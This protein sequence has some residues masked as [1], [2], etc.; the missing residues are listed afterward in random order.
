MGKNFTEIDSVLADLGKEIQESVKADFNGAKFVAEPLEDEPEKRENS[1]TIGHCV[2]YTKGGER[3]GKPAPASKAPRRI[4]VGIG[5][6]QYKDKSIRNLKCCVA[7]A[8]TMGKVACDYLGVEESNCLILVDGEATLA[9][10]RKIFTDLLPEYTQVGDEIFVYWSGHGD[11]AAS[12]VTRFNDA[13]LVPSDANVNDR[14]TM[15]GEHTFGNWLQN[16]LKGRKIIL[17]LDACHSSGM[18]LGGGKNLR[19]SDDEGSKGGLVDIWKNGAKGLTRQSDSEF[20][21]DFGDSLTSASSKSLGH[22]GMFAMA[23]SGEDELSWESAELSV[24]TYHL[25]NTLKKGDSSLTHKDLVGIIRP[26]VEKQVAKERYNAKQTVK[27]YDGIEKPV[28]LI[29]K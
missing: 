26:L 8:R 19:D 6:N 4:F 15:L 20:V 16:D 3:P 12:G 25:V 22:V 2:Y 14:M 1:V 13:F 10:I 18:L 5:I 11:K 7:D 27:A 21:F 23:S 29:R 9:A 24:A 17:F 28:K